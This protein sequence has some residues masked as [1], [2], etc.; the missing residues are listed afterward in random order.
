LACS[1][2]RYLS[3]SEA[4]WRSMEFKTHG[5]TP[6]VTTLVVHEEGKAMHTFVHGKESDALA[7]LPPSS[8]ERYLLH[9]PRDEEYNK[10]T[11]IDYFSL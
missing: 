4:V 6:A 7:K 1:E 5:R 2:H 9:R 8:L 3:A 11:Y 10:L